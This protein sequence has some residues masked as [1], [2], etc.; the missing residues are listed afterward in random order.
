MGALYQI[1]LYKVSYECAFSFANKQ[2]FHIAPD[3]EQVYSHGWG[4]KYV[5]FFSK[6]AARV[7]YCAR[8]LQ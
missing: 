7:V 1:G 6:C 5:R 2:G 3:Y 8:L 4:K